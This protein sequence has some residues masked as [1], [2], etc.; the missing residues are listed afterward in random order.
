MTTV[1]PWMTKALAA[2]VLVLA[3]VVH[4]NW[5]PPGYMLFGRVNLAGLVT[6]AIALLGMLGISGPQLSPKL[7]TMLGN[8]PAKAATTPIEPV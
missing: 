6:D 8:G 4:N 7:S 2:L 3:Y 5:I 1:K